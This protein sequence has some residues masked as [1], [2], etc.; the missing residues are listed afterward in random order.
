MVLDKRM[1]R[2]VVLHDRVEG[3]EVRALAD[4]QGWIFVGQVKSDPEKGISY[5]VKWDS[6]DNGSVHYLDNDLIDAAY[7]VAMNEVPEAAEEAIRTVCRSLAVWT[8]EELLTDV[9]TQ[10]R[11]A[12]RARALLRLGV[13]APLEPEERVIKTI[14]Q[15]LQHPDS[16]VRLASVW[17][18]AYTEWLLFMEDLDRISRKDRDREIIRTAA[19]VR[20]KFRKAGP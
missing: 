14:R 18:V 2:R 10:V 12:D 8:I 4:R 7:M 15:G 17:A 19:A 3:S 5:E 11:P 9:T 16:R 1:S 20:K 13:G 6:Q